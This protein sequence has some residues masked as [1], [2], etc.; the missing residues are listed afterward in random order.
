VRHGL[1][2]QFLGSEFA[3][4]PLNREKGS[5]LHPTIVRLRERYGALEEQ[6]KKK[7]AHFLSNNEGARFFALWTKL[8]AG[9]FE[10]FHLD[11]PDRL[12]AAQTFFITQRNRISS[13]FIQRLKL[14]KQQGC[15]KEVEEDL[16]AF[17]KFV[18]NHDEAFKFIISEVL[19]FYSN[20]LI[21]LQKFRR[22]TAAYVQS[23]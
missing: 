5:L 18:Q 19:Q 11:H 3:E 10:E 22:A 20:E 23:V 7:H 2:P 14:K 13:G 16:L 17:K 4:F 6:L 21:R 8:H 1:L 12:E 9:L 15:V